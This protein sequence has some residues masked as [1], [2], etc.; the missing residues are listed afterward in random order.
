M[1]RPPDPVEPR[2]G[3]AVALVVGGLAVHA[4]AQV[5]RARGVGWVE[6]WFYDLAWWPLVACLDGLVR[7]RTG[8][9]LLVDRPLAFALL[10]AWSCLFWLLY[11][12]ANLVLANWYYVGLPAGRAERFAGMALSFASVLPAIVELEALLASWGVGARARSRPFAVGPRLRTGLTAAGAAFLVLPLAFP[13]HAF[14]L[15]WGFLVLL[16]EPWLA[17]RDERSLLGALTAGR[18]GI[19]LRLLVAGAVAGFLWELWNFQTPSG[20]I[21][22][23]PGFEESKLFEM[24]FA[25]FLGFPPFALGC[26][27]FARLL[28]RLGLVPEPGEPA[29]RVRPARALAGA[30]LALAASLPILVRVDRST[31]RSVLVTPEVAHSLDA[32][33]RELAGVARMGLRG[34]TWLASAGIRDVAALASA[35]PDRL[36]AALRALE[37]PPPRPSDAE[38][39]VWVRRARGRQ[40]E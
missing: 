8:R 12:L 36:A 34:T 19:V 10:A 31:V 26:W 14:A 25:G 37:G 35:D 6:T 7:L 28:V 38:V 24:P 15:I 13:R 23:V 4:A 9:S 5:A 17:S 29:V 32:D 3:V 20:W 11:E 2:R 1:A 40:N 30:T 39:R 18:P 16:V 33:A 22:T 21:Y 27:T